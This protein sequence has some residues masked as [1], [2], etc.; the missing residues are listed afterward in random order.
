MGVKEEGSGL[1]ALLP[2]N[3]EAQSGNA[4]VSATHTL[5]SIVQEIL[6]ADEC[7]LTSGDGSIDYQAVEF[8]IMRGSDLAVAQVSSQPLASTVA[9]GHQENFT[10]EGR[11]GPAHVSVDETSVSGRFSFGGTGLELESL[12]NFSSLRANVAVFSG[13]WYYEC[14]VLTAG[15]QQVRSS[16]PVYQAGDTCK[17][18]PGDCVTA[19][20]PAHMQCSRRAVF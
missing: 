15:I 17:A 10:A 7:L 8:G 1:A 4:Y 19:C 16:C 2:K 9:G 5:S 14:L 13:K 11:L 3:D 18:E 20:S 12:S 6:V